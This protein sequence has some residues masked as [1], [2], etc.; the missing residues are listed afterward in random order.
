MQ[1]EDMNGELYEIY[2]QQQQLRN[3]LQDKIN[4]EGKGNRIGSSLLRKMEDVEQELLE[5]GFNERTLSKMLNLKHELLKL[6]DATI[7]QGEEE[8]RESKTNQVQ[9][10]N[11]NSQQLEKAKQY[12]NT[13][14]ILN[15]QVLPLRQNY[16]QKVQEYFK[17]DND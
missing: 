5:K 14:E 1:K 8:K 2:K 7:D 6:E 16:K 17:K 10:S 9:F 15:R 3:A 12:F 11:K 13:T 4:K